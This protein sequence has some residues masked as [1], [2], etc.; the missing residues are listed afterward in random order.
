[1][2]H[3]S[4]ETEEIHHDT[5]VP[6][7]D[8]IIDQIETAMQ[9]TDAGRVTLRVDC[10]VEGTFLRKYDNSGRPDLD[11]LTGTLAQMFHEKHEKPIKISAIIIN[12]KIQ[13]TVT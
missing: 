10:C 4:I 13:F 12:G 1:M 8:S 6:H 11:E 2:T 5:R 7:L 3:T 9:Q